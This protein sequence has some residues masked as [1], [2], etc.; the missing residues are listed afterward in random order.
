MKRPNIYTFRAHTIT[1][2]PGGQSA[3][4]ESHDGKSSRTFRVIAAEGAPTPQ[5]QAQRF[6]MGLPDWKPPAPPAVPPV[7]N[8]EPSKPAEPKAKK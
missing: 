6:V 4:V 1:V 2:Q 3:S 5:V 8:K 7:E